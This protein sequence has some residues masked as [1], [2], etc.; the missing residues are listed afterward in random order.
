M[1]IDGRTYT[2]ITNNC[3]EVQLSINDLASGYYV[4]NINFAGND[5]YKSSTDYYSMTVSKCHTHFLI[6]NDFGGSVNYQKNKEWSIRLIE[7]RNNF[8]YA[9]DGVGNA[10]IK[11][12]FTSW[13]NFQQQYVF[14]LKK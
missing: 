7:E 5:H 6:D 12:T 10:N 4:T 13:S 9:G 11:I 2:L 1:N 8:D 3:G 14:N